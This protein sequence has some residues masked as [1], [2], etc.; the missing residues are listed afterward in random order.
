MR[1]PVVLLDDGA[2]ETAL[3]RDDLDEVGELPLDT[4]VKLLRVLQEGVIRR[5][6]GNQDLHVDVRLVSATNRDLWRMVQEGRFRE[7]LYFRINVIEIPLPPLR[8]RREDIRGLA[9]FFLQREARENGKSVPRLSADAIL[10]LI[11]ADLVT[12]QT[13]VVDGG[14]CISG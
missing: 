6:G 1:D 8:E 4:Q 14:Y 10:A 7:D 9:E 2:T 12:G 3:V 5:V 13:L 11:S